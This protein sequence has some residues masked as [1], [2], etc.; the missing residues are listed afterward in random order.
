M[1]EFT[2][3]IMEISPES[4]DL[5]NAVGDNHHQKPLDAFL[6]TQT[7]VWLSVY[8][9]LKG[10]WGVSFIII[11]IKCL[12]FW[13]PSSLVHISAS[14]WRLSDLIAYIYM[15]V[16]IYTHNIMFY[17]FNVLSCSMCPLREVKSFVTED[18]SHCSWPK[19]TPVS[20][21]SL[22]W[23]DARSLRDLTWPSMWLTIK[24]VV[25]QRL[26]SDWTIE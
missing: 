23:R 8:F 5:C 7:T 18:L 1:D 22:A 13:F 26:G 15:C 25:K 11:F 19:W 4:G 12:R 14:A 20:I 3:N 16:Y 24:P 21:W 10:T 17:V 6:W 9:L 2:Q